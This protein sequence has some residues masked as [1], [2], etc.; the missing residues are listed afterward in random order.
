MQRSGSSFLVDAQRREDSWPKRPS[1]TLCK[2]PAWIKGLE[3]TRARR[4]TQDKVAISPFPDL[5][6]LFQGKH[7]RCWPLIEH[8]S[9]K[10]F[11][12]N[13]TICCIFVRADWEHR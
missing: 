7:I 8:L 1:E 10:R 11:G 5:L 6:R 3:P 2:Y 12:K 13:F 9:E 4:W